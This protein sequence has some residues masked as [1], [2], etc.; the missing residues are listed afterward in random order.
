[1]SVQKMVRKNEH[2][3]FDYDNTIAEFGGNVDYK[4]AEKIFHMILKGKK[5]SIVTSRSRLWMKKNNID[6][7]GTI[8]SYDKL[9]YKS[10]KKISENFLVYTGRGNE[11]F[12]PKIEK[13]GLFLSED[14]IYNSCM[15]FSEIVKIKEIINKKLPSRLIPKGAY[16]KHFFSSDLNGVIRVITKVKSPKDIHKKNKIIL[17]ILSELKKQD[18]EDKRLSD[19]LVEIDG[20]YLSFSFKNKA[21]AIRDILKNNP[22]KKIRYYGDSP[23]GNDKPIFDL[24]KGELKDKLICMP[25]ENPIHTLSLMEKDNDSKKI[26]KKESILDVLLDKDMRRNIQNRLEKYW[27]IMGLPFSWVNPILSVLSKYSYDEDLAVRKVREKFPSM[28][29]ERSV[30]YSKRLRLWRKTKVK[31]LAYRIHKDVHGETIVDLGGRK[32][33]FIEKIL[34]YKKEVKNAYVTD[35]GAFGGRS[36]NPKI[37]FVVQP[38]LT[39]TP[40]RKKTIDT[41]ILSLVLHHL[42][43]KDQ[44]KLV[45]HVISSLKNK[46]RIVLVEDSYPSI[47]SN[48]NANKNIEKFMDFDL[49]KRNKI[50]SFYDWFGNRIVRNR[51]NISLTFSYRTMREW[52]KLFR[53]KGATLIKSKFI[54]KENSSPDL[55]PPKA[56]M[57]F[58]KV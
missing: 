49:E 51:D 9:N 37:S 40:F 20:N 35:I 8:F 17:G 48:K 45:E 13:K 29:R 32:D 15:T 46:G 44:E 4:I 54:K 6:I 21:F 56:L 58:E 3:V 57:I 22:N 47:L 10:L 39:K 33:D 25:V 36:R 34:L 18:T 28:T 19:I 55:F 30:L 12:F 43:E 1:M 7:L 5:V 53:K 14:T 23:K 2:T 52:E 41:F 31:N 11:K 27:K 42:K 26:E 50:L 24:S 38:S 16:T